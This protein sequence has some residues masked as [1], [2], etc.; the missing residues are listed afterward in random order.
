MRLRRRR[1]AG[2][3]LSLDVLARAAAESQAERELRQRR[4]DAGLDPTPPKPPRQV[5]WQFRRMFGFAALAFM[6]IMAVVL[7]D[8]ALDDV[9]TYDEVT[10][11]V[12]PFEADG[13]PRHD[14]AD[15]LAVERLER[16]DSNTVRIA[17]WAADT[18][19][20]EVI[21]AGEVIG[22]IPVTIA[23]TDTAIANGLTTSFIGF[24]G[25]LDVPPD[26]SIC[27]ARPDQLPATGACN[28]PTLDLSTQRVVAFYGVP[29]APPL[30][31]LGDGPP[32]S[33]LERLQEQAR[34]FE[35][36]TRPV[37]LAFEIIATVAQAGPGS[38]GNYSAAIG[39]D[40][41]WDFVDTIRDGG[42]VALID[43]QT[44][45]DMYLDQVP[46]YVDFLSEPDIH[47]ALDPEWDMEEG[48]LPNE[49][50]GSSDA[51]EINDVMAFV[52]DIIRENR[53]PRKVMVVHNFT[54]GMIADRDM[55]DP[56]LEIDLVIHMDGHGTP[57]NKI[58]V[59]DR[60]AADPP[61]YNG[62]KL[63]YQRDF[64]LMTPE[65]VLSLD[66]GFIS[67]Q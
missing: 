33:V 35:S 57:Q 62:F 58:G 31:T 64:P 40:E 1:K 18:D 36:E 16:T 42:G 46:D 17:G 51:S 44:G 7:R 39:T 12:P 21:A 5:D 60:L 49:F 32:E 3:G 19:R 8:P 9:E 30:G 4:V 66:P 24:D 23:R 59:Y 29:F 53:L 6:V 13:P 38:D 10:L 48:E 47:I 26:T 63:F 11:V 22:T 45:R 15:E 2:Q 50:I 55:L 67:Y 28:R 43:F 54:E 61:F 14:R 41:I 25:E 56:P 27:I 34:P 52:A 65:A 20:V 37:M